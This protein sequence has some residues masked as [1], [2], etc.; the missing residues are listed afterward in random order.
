MAL[1]RSQIKVPTLPKEAVQVDGLG[2][3]VVVRGLR[4]SERLQLDALNR[5]ASAPREGEPEDE[6]RVRAGSLA[7]PRVL[8]AC[9]V[10]GDG[11]PLMSA[12]E[13]DIFG[14]K[15]RTEAFVLFNTA[16]RLSGQD[17]AELEKN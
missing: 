15:H 4:L 14:A 1:D 6:A 13:W 2:G 7:L 17:Q 10:D 16:M 8:A 11:E 12:A 3:E 9:V 5:L